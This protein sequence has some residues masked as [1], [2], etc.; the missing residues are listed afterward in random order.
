[1]L[2]TSISTIEGMKKNKAEFL[3]GVEERTD[4]GTRWRPASALISWETVS[5]LTRMLGG[6]QKRSGR[7]KLQISWFWRGAVETGKC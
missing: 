7:C 3:C 6:P 5:L 2:I 4:L 1:M